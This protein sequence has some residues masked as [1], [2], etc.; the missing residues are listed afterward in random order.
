M[1]YVL[2]GYQVV[3]FHGDEAIETAMSIDYA[4][5]FIEQDLSKVLYS[6]APY[7]PVEQ[8]YRLIDGSVIRYLIG[9]AWHLDG[10]TQ[11]DLN[12]PWWFAKSFAFNMEN[13]YYPGDDLLLTSRIPSTI[14]T[15]GSVLLLFIMGMRLQ[16][17]VT[18]YIAS[19]FF[20][21]HPVILID[22]RRAKGEGIHLFFELFVLLAGIAFLGLVERRRWRWLWLWTVALGMGSGVAGAA[23][24][25]NAIV[26]VTVFLSILIYGI[27]HA[28]PALLR[29][30]IHLVL[31]SALCVATF[32]LLNPAWW[33]NP[34]TVGA[35]VIQNRAEVV[36][37][38]IADF[39]NSYRNNVGLR[40]R[41]LWSL[42]LASES[43]M[44]YEAPEWADY[45][46]GQID[47]YESTNLTGINLPG[48]GLP[49]TGLVILGYAVMWGL[50]K[51]VS[52]FRPAQWVLSFWLAVLLI[53]VVLLV[54]LGW[55][56]YYIPVFPMLGMTAGL[57]VIWVV[58]L[59]VRDAEQYSRQYTGG[60]ARVIPQE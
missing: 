51:P 2:A 11:D 32:L 13:G 4:Y 41:G 15:A 60:S 55:Q 14:L 17:R 40:L 58:N 37:G 25:T 44:Y 16:G 38:Q 33:T 7:N 18:A 42:V 12:V 54:P 22:G 8:G 29:I 26:V 34:V 3:P 23:K 43:P 21:L 35:L 52:L 9:V 48:T 28:R 10:F 36:T 50:L 31:A 1:L 47:V 53:Y 30:V 19:L 59:Y 56:R 57:G 27:V 6:E 45:I 20:A 5:L 39:D 46:G 24:H 49:L